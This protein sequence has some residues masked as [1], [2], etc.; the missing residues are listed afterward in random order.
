M[1]A[2]LKAEVIGLLKGKII[3][4]ISHSVFIGRFSVDSITFTNGT[5]L[6]LSGIADQAIIVDVVLP[7][8]TIPNIEIDD[9]G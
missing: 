4:D 2:L 7:D 5:V 8:R 9:E 3:K 6:V 1:K